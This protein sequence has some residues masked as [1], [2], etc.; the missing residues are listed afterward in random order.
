M[1]PNLRPLDKFI[2]TT[3]RKHRIPGLAFLLA[4]NGRRLVAKGYGYRDVAERLPV[5][6]RTI[7]GI[8]SVTKS[9]TALGILRLQEEGRL[10]VH[11]P[12]VRHLPEFGTPAPRWTRRIQLHHFLTH[13]SG[14]PP[15]PSIYYSSGRSLARDPVNDPRVARRVG[16]DPNHPPIDTYDQM[17][18]YLRTTRYTLLGPPGRCFS[19]SNEAFG[20]LGAVIERVSGRHFES[21]LEE[22]I[23]R[24]AGLRS[25]TFDTGI[26]FRSPEVTTLYSPPLPPRKRGWG[27][28]QDW[29]EDTC[30]RGAG[31]L[32]T[33]LEDLERYLE[34]FRTGGRVDG[35][36]IVGPTSLRAMM[37]PHVPVSPG[38]FYGYGLAVQP[39]FPGGPLVSHSGGLKGVSSLIAMLPKRGIASAV[40]CNL[41]MAPS[42]L[43]VQAGINLLVR[44]PLTQPLA[45]VPPHPPRPVTIREYAGVYCSGEGIWFRARPVRRGLRI[46]FIG[47][48]HTQRNLRYAPN[49]HDEFIRGRR[50]RT[51]YVRFE[52]DARGRVW[53]AFVGWRLVRRRSVR[54]LPLARHNRM[55]W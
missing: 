39:E 29:W 35:S 2:R 49:G 36:R 55:V 19:Y 54:E 17:L 46:D 32:R 23:L 47:I 51:G 8:A 25:T 16:I 44:R 7:F 40:L 52:R 41:G 24:P 5:T 42:G 26:M 1:P 43:T 27:A 13:S 18:E 28:S 38:V 50:G 33:N 21:F 3:A 31:A 6:P 45:D 20:L 37:R 34:I 11:D 15:L 48:E 10:R 12:V 9:F 22:E 4:Q 30:L 14:L 53:A